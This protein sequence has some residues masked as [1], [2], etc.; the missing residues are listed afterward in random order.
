LAHPT[1]SKERFADWL[2]HLILG[3]V[4][5]GQKVQRNTNEQHRRYFFENARIAA[6]D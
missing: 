4:E 2:A 5:Q 1:L 3:Q 6:A